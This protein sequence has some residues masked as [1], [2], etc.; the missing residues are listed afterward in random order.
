MSRFRLRHRQ[1][2]CRR[3][4]RPRRRSLLRRNAEFVISGGGG[5]VVRPRSYLPTRAREGSQT[6]LQEREGI[7]N[8]GDSVLC[9]TRVEG[10][11]RS[12]SASAFPG[13]TRTPAS[14]GAGGY[15]PTSNQVYFTLLLARA[16]PL[17][18]YSV[19]LSLLARL[20]IDI[21][22]GATIVGTQLKHHQY[23]SRLGLC[24]R[25]RRRLFRGGLFG[26]CFCGGAGFLLKFVN[27]TDK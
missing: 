12:S 8:D 16:M 2:C 7:P 9:H 17:L 20:N 6:M 1:G 26:F 13:S 11:C 19:S 15:S 22:F 25:R 23:S 10:G 18:R 27:A 4:R 3:S 14:T 5:F 21:M 24:L